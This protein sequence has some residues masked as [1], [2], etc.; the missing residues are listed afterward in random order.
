M[1]WSWKSKVLF[2]FFGWVYFLSFSVERL[3]V[4]VATK[5]W[6]LLMQVP[7]YSNDVTWNI[8]APFPLGC[9]PVFLRR[10]LWNVMCF[11]NYV[12]VYVRWHRFFQHVVSKWFTWDYFLIPDSNQVRGEDSSDCL[13]AC[14]PWKFNRPLK[15]C[16]PKRK[17]SFPTIIFSGAMLNFAGVLSSRW[18]FQICFI[19]N[20]TWG[21]FR[22]WLIFFNWVETTN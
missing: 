19:S 7:S 20:P 5:I 2:C 9:F 17:G 13:F 1:T 3:S 6:V 11:K 10:P 4:K 16:H 14:I 12:Y 18:W 22:I 21:N 15:H 8:M